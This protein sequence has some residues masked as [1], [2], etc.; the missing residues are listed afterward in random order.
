M[1]SRNYE[2]KTD[3]FIKDET[4]EEQVEQKKPAPKP[5]VYII[6]VTNLALRDAPN[7]NLLGVANA[8]RTLIDR[9][10]DG[11]GHLADNSGWVSMKYTRKAQ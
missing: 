1:K 2:K 4:Q 3:D 9:I 5:Q 11:F 8:G 10:Q 7:G 6:T